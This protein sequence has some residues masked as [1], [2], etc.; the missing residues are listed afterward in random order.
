MIG[1]RVFLLAAILAST[2]SS[3]AVEQAAASGAEHA[4]LTAMAGTWDVEMTFWLRPGGPG[5]TSKGVSTIQPLFDGL[6]IEEKIE[7]TLTGKPFTTLAWTGFNT[8]THRYEATRIAS[9]NTIRIV[10]T[11]GYDESTKQFELKADYPLAGDTWHQRTVIQPMSADTMTAAS[12]LS[13]GT[14]P[15]WKSVEIKYTRRTK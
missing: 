12:Y 9:T 3:G 14:V 8:V 11:G 10:E 1:L 6:F 15:E 5:I 4:R 2:A 13:F 7:G